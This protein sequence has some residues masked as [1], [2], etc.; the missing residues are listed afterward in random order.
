MQIY[1]H[2]FSRCCL[3]NMPKPQ[4][5]DKISTYSSSKSSKFDDF[6]TNQKRICDFLLVT[7]SNFGP[8]LHRFWDRGDFLAE[9]CIFLYPVLFGARAPYV[10]C[11]ISQWS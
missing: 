5:S 10:L 7:N 8:I 2:S 6:G 9:N 4:N 11:G 3:P 1:F